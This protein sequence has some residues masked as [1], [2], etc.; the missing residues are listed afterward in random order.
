ASNVADDV[1]A[2]HRVVAALKG[3]SPVSPAKMK[4]HTFD[5]LFILGELFPSGIPMPVSAGALDARLAMESR[6]EL[7][8]MEKEKEKQLK[9]KAEALKVA[10]AMGKNAKRD[11]VGSESA[12][13]GSR[14]D[15][16]K[17][18]RGGSA[19]SASA[20]PAGFEGT[21]GLAPGEIEAM[22]ERTKATPV[23][24]SVS[25]RGVTRGSRGSRDSKEREE[26]SPVASGAGSR[27]GKEAVAPTTKP[28]TARKGMSLG[29]APKKRKAKPTF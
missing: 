4:A 3:W 14:R 20:A 28:V 23:S 5:A 10:S 29:A 13:L 21:H 16:A 9:A 7:E 27:S 17:R 25:K 26:D 19:A 15:K 24:A 8:E 18:G 11:G 2:L 6:A 22:R 1:D 12:S